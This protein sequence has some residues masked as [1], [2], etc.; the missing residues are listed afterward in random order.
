[1]GREV[2]LAFIAKVLLAALGFV[3]SV[4]FARRLGPAA[5]GAFYVLLTVGRLLDRPLNGLA[6]AAKHR[7]AG[8]HAD[9][10]ELVGLLWIAVFATVALIGLGAFAFAPQLRAYADHPAAPSLLILLVGALGTIVVSTTLVSATGR[11]SI[12]SGL[13]L[14]ASVLTIPLQIGLVVLGY[15]IWG[16]T[17]GFVIG[18]VV[19]AGVGFAFV[20]VRPRL[21]SRPTL[22]SVWEY[23]RFN[24]LS[25]VVNKAYSRFDVLLLAWLFSTT[26]AGYYEVAWKVTI[27]A[28]YVAHSIASSMVARTSEALSE[29]SLSTTAADIRAGRNY[30]SI[31]ALPLLGGA[32]VLSERVVVTLYGPEYAAASTL[33]IGLAAY[34]VVRTQTLPYVAA[35]DGADRPDLSFKIG[36]ATLCANIVLGVALAL[37]LGPVGVVI[38]TIASETG[39]HVLGR[40]AVGSALELS[41][42][43]PTGVYAQTVAAATMTVMVWA[44]A[45][46]LTT[47][48]QTS[49]TS[50]SALL[51]LVT[52]GA[53][54]YGAGLVALYDPARDALRRVLT[55]RTRMQPTNSD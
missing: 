12:E 3:G 39:R 38:A 50:W 32:L 27:P 1:M 55:S 40:R 4:V 42:G 10:G 18:S 46:G 53:A 34:Q 19:A 14:L 49:P 48:S 15:G 6:G 9:T 8:S 21:P 45:R 5:F 11:V 51:G 26:A 24:I 47:L 54:S 25:R 30:G 20:G 43:R 22:K 29:G 28:I 33:L 36:V 17:A 44:L 37:T 52:V 16:M 31:L 13:S 41:I 7:F 35:L 2:S 23:A